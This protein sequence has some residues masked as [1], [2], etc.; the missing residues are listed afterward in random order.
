MSMVSD[1]QNKIKMKRHL[2]ILNLLKVYSWSIDCEKFKV[3][4]I[5]STFCVHR[6]SS[7]FNADGIEKIEFHYC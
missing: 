2:L 1:G 6:S 4:A 7:L 3:I 5:G